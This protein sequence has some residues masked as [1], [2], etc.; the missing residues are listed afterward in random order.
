MSTAEFFVAVRRTKSVD[1]SGSGTT[2]D[3]HVKAPSLADAIA[4]AVAES[5]KA[6]P[7]CNYFE[8]AAAKEKK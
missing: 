5:K 4:I 7:S 2:S 3:H 8:V 1:G 6:N